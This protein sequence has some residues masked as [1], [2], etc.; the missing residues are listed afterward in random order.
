MLTEQDIKKKI[1]RCL[2]SKDKETGRCLAHCLDLDVMTSATTEESAWANLRKVVR[3]H[4][5]HCFTF[6][7]DGLKIE[8]DPEEFAEFERVVA[9]C[10]AEGIP[11]RTEK[12]KLRL[13]P[14]Q[15][16]LW[17]EMWMTGVESLGPKATTACV[18]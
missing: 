10:K 13:T 17:D 14:P 4:I 1:F 2:L 11:M 9:R 8:A 16:Q 18:H 6:H 15:Q 3:A 12:I 7:Q 5:E